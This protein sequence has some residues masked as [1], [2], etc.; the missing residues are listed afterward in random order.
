MCS[1]HRFCTDIKGNIG[2]RSDWLSTVIVWP[3]TGSPTYIWES[4]SKLLSCLLSSFHIFCLIGTASFIQSHQALGGSGQGSRKLEL[5]CHICAQLCGYNRVF[6]LTH[7]GWWNGKN[8]WGPRCTYK[9]ILK[10][11]F[12]RR[13]GPHEQMSANSDYRK[14]RPCGWIFNF[15]NDER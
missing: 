6:F 10:M 2:R 3:Q 15:R 5:A 13:A 11:D 14:P 7:S 8:G 12:Y 1:W 4:L 9:A